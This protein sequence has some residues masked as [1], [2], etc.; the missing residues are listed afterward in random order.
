VPGRRRRSH[1]N[2][3]PRDFFVITCEH[4]GNR[5]PA[6]YRSLFS[7]ADAVL[8]THRGYDAGA[9]TFAR[10][11][12]DA[13]HA[14]LF[15]ATTSRLVIDLNRSIGHSRLY[16]EFTRAA[17]ATVRREIMERCYLPYRS[18]VEQ[19]ISQAVA[20][21]YRVIHL[22]SHSF[23]PDLDGTTRNNDIGLLYDPARSAESDFCRRWQRALRAQDIPPAPLKTRLN[24]PYTGTA[25]GFTVYLRRRFPS[26]L[27]LGIEIEINQKHAS[28]GGRHWR[29][30]RSAFV[31][32][33]QTALE[34]NEAEHGRVPNKLT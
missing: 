17:S 12:G 29:T 3:P 31:K 1:D 24:Y 28:Q 22:S 2:Y 32:A 19:R 34:P 26:D 8:R 4:G 5:I 9:L 6:R 11:L 16:S 15:A 10:D 7:G 25:D 23:T 33:L 30:V 20:R 27:Y 21:G 13:L 18:D 14:P